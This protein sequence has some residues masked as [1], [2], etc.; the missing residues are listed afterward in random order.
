MIQDGTAICAHCE[1]RLDPTVCF[2]S[3]DKCGGSLQRRTS[4]YACTLCG[5][6][7]RSRFAFDPIVFDRAYFARMMRKSRQRRKHHRQQIQERLRSARSNLFVPDRKPDLGD[8]PDL[9]ESLNHMAGL[10]LPA[11]LIERFLRDPGLDMKRY[12]HH[13]LHHI[14]AYGVLFDK[15]PPLLDN[16]RR[17][18][19]FR[20]VVAVFMW[21]EGEVMLTQQNQI[22]VVARYESNGEG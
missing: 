4:H 3:C 15:I 21:Q 2:Q 11:E 7:T 5:A 8:I 20:F 16:R 10:P 1:A 18:R 9:S 19:I 14:D 13:I 22:L 12:R 6:M 17:D